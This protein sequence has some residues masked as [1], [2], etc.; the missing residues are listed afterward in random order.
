[1]GT[2][3]YNESTINLDMFST[4]EMV[5][6]MNE[7]DKNVP[8]A[9]EKVIPDIARAI[10]MITE[11]FKIGGRLIYVGAG[12]SGRLG[13]LDAAE[14]HPTFGVSP[15]MVQGIIAGGEKAI[16]TPIEFAEDDLNQGKIVIKTRGINEKD[17]VV[18]ITASGTTPFVIGALEE[19]H[20]LRAGTIL[21]TNNYGSPIKHLVDVAIEIDTGPEVVAGSTRLKAGTSQKMVL[22]MLS[23]LSM[24]KIGKVYGNIMV[25]VKPTNQK[26]INRAVR[27]IRRFT[28][29]SEEVALTKLKECNMSVKEAIVSIIG[30]LSPRE[31]R[32]ILEECNGYLRIA[33]E[34]VKRTS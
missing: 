1:M 34:R 5:K 4:I 11:R 17:V 22:N 31:S 29:V 20:R 12:T 13:V 28:G 18:G 14:C 2:E 8:L 32:R 15:D 16:T 9:V 23:T 6:I 21:I 33:L 19:A 26:L 7:E 27:I 24:V 25:D 3:D 30:N 10:D